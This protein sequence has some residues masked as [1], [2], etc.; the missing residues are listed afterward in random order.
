MQTLSLYEINSQIA[1]LL[2][3]AVD[4]DTGEILN[5]TALAEV[6]TLELA[7]AE[8]VKNVGLYYK[9]LELTSEAIKSE[10][11]KLASFKKIVDNRSASMK[12]YLSEQLEEGEK[13]ELP[14]LRISWRKSSSVDIDDSLN[15]KQ[16]FEQYPTLAEE[17]IDYKL[18]KT[19]IKKYLTDSEVKIDGV[20]IIDKQNIQIK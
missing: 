4:Y 12:V 10:M 11:A 8:K 9:N 15:R 6:E 16:F 5:E 20:K 1:E 2:D 17:V 19:A 18:D 3:S 13:V 14:N 7:R